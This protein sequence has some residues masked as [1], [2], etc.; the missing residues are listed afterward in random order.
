MG[1]DADD[2]DIW[3]DFFELFPDSG[4]G[5]AGACPDEDVVDFVFHLLPDFWCGVV[6][7]RHPVSVVVV[8]VDVHA[9]SFFGESFGSVEIACVKRYV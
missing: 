7:M 3:V 1:V 6:E 2:F 9:T 5:S 8:L 4:E